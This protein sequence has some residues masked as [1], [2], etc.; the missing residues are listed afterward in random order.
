MQAM[1]TRRSCLTAACVWGVLP[2]LVPFVRGNENGNEPGG[3]SLSNAEFDTLFRLIRPQPGE[4]R[5]MEIAWHPSVW[6]ARQIA[7]REGKPLF[8]WAGSGGAPAAGC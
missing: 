6:E 7:A 4:S 5:W 8:L 1:W 3:P 2:N